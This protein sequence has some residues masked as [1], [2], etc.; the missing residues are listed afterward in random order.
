[1]N[2]RIKVKEIFSHPWVLGFEKQVIVPKSKHDKNEGRISNDNDNNQSKLS[3]NSLQVEKV[4]NNSSSNNNELIKNPKTVLSG[5]FRDLSPP[6]KDDHVNVRKNSELI[7]HKHL[8]NKEKIYDM[9]DNENLNEMINSHRDLNE[10][11][12]KKPKSSVSSNLFDQVLNK[13]QEKN[14]IKSN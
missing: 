13:V 5:N 11:D 9:K 8:S 1:L 3:S 6:K 7:V 14:K 12:L 4:D 10:H 2:N